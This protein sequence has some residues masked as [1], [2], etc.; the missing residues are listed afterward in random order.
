MSE[1]IDLTGISLI[2]RT[3]ALK[4]NRYLE[5]ESDKLDNWVQRMKFLKALGDCGG[6][7]IRACEK[8]GI[9]YTSYSYYLKKDP[10]FKEAV[11]LVRDMVEKRQL[12]ELEEIS[13]KNAKNVD[14]KTGVADRLF[15]M[16]ALDREKYDPQKHIISASGDNIN[17]IFGTERPKFQNIEDAEF[18]ITDN[19]KKDQ[20][21]LS[22]KNT[23]KKKETTK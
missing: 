11:D 13:F 1:N 23:R 4:P 22:A 2:P 18:H 15:L 17:I 3:G 16:K 14:S 7:A 10:E 5:Y 12:T 21:R 9:K 8:L 19:A 20:K 6:R